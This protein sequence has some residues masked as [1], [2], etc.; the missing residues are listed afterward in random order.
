MSSLWHVRSK[1][2]TTPLQED[3]N[4]SATNIMDYDFCLFYMND[5]IQSND[6]WLVSKIALYLDQEIYSMEYVLKLTHTLFRASPK[7]FKC[8]EFEFISKNQ[9]AVK[10]YQKI[11]ENMLIKL[12]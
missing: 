2:D 8:I 12:S 4:Y 1:K 11:I 5:L 6:C 7:N 10:A 3:K 9:H